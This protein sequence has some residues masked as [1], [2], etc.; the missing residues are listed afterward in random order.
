MNIDK[1]REFIYRNARLLDFARWKYLFENG[2]KEDVLSVLATYQNADGGF[3][4]G[5]EPDFWNPLSS[6][7]QTWVAT[8][9]I[10]ELDLQDNKHPIIQGILNYL[11]SGLDFN[12]HTWRNTVPTNN[13]YPHAPWWTF[14]PVEVTYNPTASLV[15]FI[16]KFSDRG[17]HLF[18]LGSILAQEA[19]AH[20][21]D[22]HPLKE[23]HT[24]ACYVELYEYLKDSS[25]HDIIDLQEFEDLLHK[26]IQHVITHD[27]STWATEYVCKPSLFIRSKASDFYLAN[28]Y[29]CYYE[30]EFI[31]N[32]QESDGTWAVTW[33][34]A[35]Y[36]EEWQV[37][38]NRWKS[39]LI[40]RNLK[41][42]Q[43]MCD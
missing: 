13:D 28:M 43:V 24:V 17:S 14:N 15:G 31:A 32:T 23:M 39:D 9:I 38:K 40:I 25:L 33:A 27:V 34:W 4:H 36:P 10:H 41:F 7:V 29:T 8:R 6:P 11:E 22:H 2:S 26:Q 42:L 19:Y 5:L 35:E 21:K 20:F 3:G 1:A 12:R 37:S 16:L 18:E 30:C